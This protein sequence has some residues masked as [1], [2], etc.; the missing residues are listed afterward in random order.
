MEI[1][2]NPSLNMFL[3]RQNDKGEHEKILSEIDKY[4]K[5]LVLDD[6]LRIVRSK[7]PLE[8]LGWFEQILPW[9]EESEKFYIWD[10]AREVFNLLSG[11]KKSQFITASQFQKLGRCPELTSS[12]F[13]KAHYDIIFK[14]VIR[15]NDSNY[16]NWEEFFNALEQVVNQ[17][18]GC[19]FSYENLIEYIN[20]VLSVIRK[21]TRNNF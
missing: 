13:S 16:M 8:D 7:K 21:P 10:K 4:L 11:V 15:K 20:E 1:N 6:A 18:Y 12:D 5:T 9:D 3:E 2:A 19:P 17:F 14:K